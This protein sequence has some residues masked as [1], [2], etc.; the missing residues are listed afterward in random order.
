MKCQW[1]DQ[2]HYCNCSTELC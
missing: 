2:L 1:T